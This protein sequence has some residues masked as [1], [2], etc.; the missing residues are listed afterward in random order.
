[1]QMPYQPGSKVRIRHLAGAY[2]MVKTLLFRGRRPY[3]AGWN[4]IFIMQ[5]PLPMGAAR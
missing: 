5:G 4:I 1:M 2:Q 3:D